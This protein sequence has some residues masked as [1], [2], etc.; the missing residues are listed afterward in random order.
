VSNFPD[1]KEVG[2]G[3]CERPDSDHPNAPKLKGWV[4]IPALGDGFINFTMWPSKKKPGTYSIK[5]EE[6]Q[7]PKKQKYDRAG[8]EIDPQ[9]PPRRRLDDTF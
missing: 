4:K 2:Y 6:S 3:A 9:A 1:A 5:L 8:D 7:A